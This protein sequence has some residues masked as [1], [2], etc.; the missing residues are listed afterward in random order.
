MAGLA[1][2]GLLLLFLGENPAVA[3][4]TLFSSLFRDRYTLADVFVKATPLMFTALA[5]AFTYQANLY[6]IGA[7]GQFY[8]GSVTAVALSLFLEGKA[9]GPAGTPHHHGRDP[10]LRRA[11][12]RA[13]RLAQGQVQRQRIPRQH[14]VD[15]C[16]AQHHELPAPH[17]PDGN[18][19]RVPADEPAGQCRLAADD[20]AGHTVARGLSPRRAVLHWHLGPPVQTP[21]GFRIRAVGQ[22]KDAAELAGINYKR[23][24]VVAF[25]VSGAMAAMG[26]FAEVNGV[27]HMLVQGFNPDVGAAGIGIAILANGNPI[28]IIFAA[29]LFGALKVGGTLMG[30]FSGIPSSITDLMLGFVM[31]FVILGYY[32]REKLEVRRERARLK[33]VVTA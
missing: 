1:V 2:S 16:R 9:A 14:D 15:V 25:F 31:V 8:I 30:Q 12:G 5:F 33:R 11:V 21:L 27:Q 3:M 19:R 28:G 24:Y 6:N 10:R 7:Q 22:G 32:V 13:D 23:L 18:Q 26:G 29:I 4:G 17:F 20:P